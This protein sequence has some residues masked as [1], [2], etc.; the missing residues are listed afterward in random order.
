MDP[1][2]NKRLP[3]PIGTGFNAYSAGNKH[4]GGG[5]LAPNIGPVGDLLGYK[6]RDLK[7]SARQNAIARL[8]KAQDKGNPMNFNYLNFLGGGNS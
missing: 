5:R 2:G 6:S 4:Y 8:M 3:T 1:F 7:R